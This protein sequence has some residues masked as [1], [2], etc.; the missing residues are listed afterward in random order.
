MKIWD[1]V[2]SVG[3][4]VIREAVPGGGLLVDAV[5]AFLPDDNKLPADATGGDLD[6]VVQ[7]LPPEHRAELLG[8]EFDVDISQIRQSNETVR[9]MLEADTKTPQTT[10]PY[11]AKGAFH[12]VA[13]TVIVTVATWAYSII[14]GREGLTES[15]SSGWPFVLSVIGPFIVLLHAYFGVLRTEQRNRLHAAS[16]KPGPAGLAGV[17]SNL[18]KR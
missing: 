10:R 16:G 14:M 13:F 15:V 1:V 12:V 11:I 8:K 17:L 18:I 5:N 6:R 3:S 2:K 7:S 4:S 9:A